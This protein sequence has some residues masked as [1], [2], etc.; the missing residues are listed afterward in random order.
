MIATAD[1]LE[2]PARDI[3]LIEP[4]PRDWGGWVILLIENLENEAHRRRNYPE[5]EKVLKKLK[6]QIGK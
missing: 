4:N 6:P 2:E 3:A 1:A 5:F